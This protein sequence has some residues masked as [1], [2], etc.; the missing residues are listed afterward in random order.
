M[1]LSANTTKL[2]VKLKPWMR[3]FQ[4]FSSSTLVRDIS[5]PPCHALSQFELS[6]DYAVNT[7]KGYLS[8]DRGDE[9]DE[10]SSGE[11]DVVSS[12]VDIMHESDGASQGPT[13][14]G[15]FSINS[16]FPLAT[17]DD[18]PEYDSQVELS[19]DDASRRSESEVDKG[20]GR[21]F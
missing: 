16:S 5:P 15:N 13:T 7:P 9:N 3:P 21:K 2:L 12:S 6:T 19:D 17:S 10:D 8:Q 18:I 11:T 20:R 1:I 4:R 14:S